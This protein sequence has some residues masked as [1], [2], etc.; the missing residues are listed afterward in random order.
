MAMLKLA[1]KAVALANGWSVELD[2]G[3]NGG[4]D[5]AVDVGGSSCPP[6]RSPPPLVPPFLALC[7]CT[8]ACACP[9]PW[10]TSVPPASSPPAPNPSNP[11]TAA[12][13]GEPAP[14]AP[15]ATIPFIGDPAPP[16][17]PIPGTAG[18]PPGSSL[19]RCAMSRLTHRPHGRPASH[20]MCER[21]QNLHASATLDLRVFLGGLS[22]AAAGADVEGVGAEVDATGEGESDDSECER[23]VVAGAGRA[24]S[25]GGRGGRDMEMESVMDW[26]SRRVGWWG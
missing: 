12:G 4:I 18:I 14:L 15:P 8:C 16:G 13:A 26:W 23:D 3:A 9:C 19:Q 22:L 17:L 21:R 24:G 10:S 7:T 6:S 11:L 25:V 2:A 1:L 5:D 20:D